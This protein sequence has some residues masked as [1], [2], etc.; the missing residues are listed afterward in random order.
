MDAVNV[1][2]LNIRNRNIFEDV[3]ENR[4]KPEIF[5][6][7]NERGVQPK[8]EVQQWSGL[9]DEP[10]ISN[11]LDPF[12][13]SNA[14]AEDEDRPSTFHLDGRPI[15]ST[16]LAADILTKLSEICTESEDATCPHFVL[17][18]NFTSSTVSL[19]SNS[20]VPRALPDTPETKLLWNIELY[21]G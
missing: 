18:Y 1:I 10:A 2:E 6:F 12:A 20:L 9:T 15:N 11:F 16:Q 14:A 7:Y 13:S 5:R 8:F 3:I 19:L 21:G 17:T 4:V